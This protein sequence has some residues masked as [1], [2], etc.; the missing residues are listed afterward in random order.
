MT[1]ADML[2]VM[3]AGRVEQIGAP[4]A[5]YEKP[6]T[7]F[8][9]SFIGAPPMNLLLLTR[10]EAATLTEGAPL[11]IPPDGG[12]VG[13]RPED[14]MLPTGGSRPSG[15]FALDL[16]IGAVEHVGPETFIYGTLAR[17][18]DI[19]VRVPG[20]ST[21]APGERVSAVAERHRLHVFSA[22]G[23][24]RLSQTGRH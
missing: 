7:T 13:V 8:V 3:N 20:Q 23:R 11:E 19:I 9:A 5:V 18:G 24:R 22:D 10:A 15:S 1:L 21:L 2:V 16:T 14:L 6:L 17:G 12:I 4:L